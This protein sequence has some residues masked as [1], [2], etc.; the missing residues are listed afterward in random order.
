M[1]M[2]IQSLLAYSLSFGKKM[3]YIA[4]ASCHYAIDNNNSPV[5]VFVAVRPAPYTQR[6]IFSHR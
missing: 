2:R 4:G 5:V 3:A 1:N 6:I